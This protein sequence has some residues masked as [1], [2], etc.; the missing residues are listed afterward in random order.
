MNSR[1]FRIRAL[2]ETIFFVCLFAAFFWEASGNYF[3]TEMGRKEAI[4]QSLNLA[5]IVS[6]WDSIAAALGLSA[7]RAMQ[8]SIS[9][10]A[11]CLWIG[12][13]VAAVGYSFAVYVLAPGEQVGPFRNALDS[14]CFF[15]EGYGMMFPITWV[16]L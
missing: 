13:G 7:G 6:V 11:T 14:S 15:T 2:T 8:G 5:F 3:C 10:K 1:E 12:G 16:P 9:A 4:R